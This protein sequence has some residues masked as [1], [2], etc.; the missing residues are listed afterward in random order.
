MP[1]VEDLRE[2]GLIGSGT[3][4]EAYMRVTA[5]R[6][7]LLRTHEWDD[8]IIDRLREAMR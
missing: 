5:D 2:A 6:Y 1:V 7:M 3:E 4:A 8:E